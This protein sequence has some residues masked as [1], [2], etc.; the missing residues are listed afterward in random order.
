MDEALH[1]STGNTI[2][3]V[4]RREPLGVSDIAGASIGEG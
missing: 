4:K 1:N 2:T 3:L